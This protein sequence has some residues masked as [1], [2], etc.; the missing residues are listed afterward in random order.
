MKA[1]VTV[2]EQLCICNAGTEPRSC[3]FCSLMLLPPRTVLHIWHT[4]TYCMCIPSLV[5]SVICTAEA[6]IRG[7]TG[8][9]AKDCST[10]RSWIFTSNCKLMFFANLIH[11]SATKKARHV[12]WL[13]LK[14]SANKGVMSKQACTYIL[15]NNSVLGLMVNL[16]NPD[17]P[18][19]QA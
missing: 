8:W 3:D 5:L 16:R 14:P 10:P 7:R 2:K 19:C 15:L 18:V 17:N 11:R 9:W 1:P 12:F 6:F 4:C 13:L